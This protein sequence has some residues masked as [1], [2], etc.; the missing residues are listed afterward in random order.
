M[1]QPRYPI[2]IP[3]KGRFNKNFTAMSFEQMGVDYTVFVEPQEYEEYARAIG[4]HRLHILQHQDQGLTVTRNYIWDYAKSHGFK[5]FWT[6]DDNIYHL[7]RLNRNKK[8]RV[9]DPTILAVMENFVERYTNVPIAGMNYHGFA[10]QSTKMQ[11]FQLNT[12]VYSNML[13]ETDLRDSN[14]LEVRNELYYNDD[15]DLCLRVLKSGLCTILFNAFLID[16]E[17]TM[18][19]DGGMTTDYKKDGRKVFAQE[20]VDAHPDVTTL[21]QKFGRWHHQ[22]DYSS[23]KQKLIRVDNYDDIVGHGI[24]EYGMKLKNL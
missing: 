17:V 12:R 2:F 5:R 13:I 1:L 7:Y 14:G 10:Q 4:K 20:L 21:T 23:F 6:F 15:T 8:M 16:K 11:P 24:N 22:V 9:L 3:S 19:H 18:R